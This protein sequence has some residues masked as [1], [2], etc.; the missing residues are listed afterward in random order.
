VAHDLKVSTK[1]LDNLLADRERHSFKMKL[2]PYFL[3]KDRGVMETIAALGGYKVSRID[4]PSPEEQLAALKAVLRTQG[5]VGRLL[6]ERA[7]VE[8]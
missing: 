5:D 8:G 6:L 1:V 7:G 4:P 2:L 3:V